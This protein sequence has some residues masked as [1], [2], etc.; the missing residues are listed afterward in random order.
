MDEV[1]RLLRQRRAVLE[2]SALGVL[3]T[4]RIVGDSGCRNVM[5]L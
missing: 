3:A 2:I 4:L 1:P 5:G